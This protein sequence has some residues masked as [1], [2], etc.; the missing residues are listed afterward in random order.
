MKLWPLLGHAISEVAKNIIFVIFRYET[1]PA[2]WFAPI[3]TSTEL[4]LEPTLHVI[5]S[6]LLLAQVFV[7]LRVHSPNHVKKLVLR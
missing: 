2:I 4:A 6:V 5:H 7:S 1:A 3:F